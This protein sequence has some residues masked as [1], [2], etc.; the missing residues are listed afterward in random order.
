MSDTPRHDGSWLD[1]WG[2]CKACGG[3]IPH[4]HSKNCDIYKLQMAEQERDQ[5][6]QQLL[7]S[8]L[9]EQRMR[10]VLELVRAEH[11]RCMREVSEIGYSEYNYSSSL[12]CAVNAALSIPSD[13]SL[14]KEIREALLKIVKDRVP[15]HAQSENLIEEVKLA[16]QLLGGGKL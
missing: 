14:L 6:K 16:L 4:G 8:Q 1:E 3:E 12:A 9:R 5:L 2:S 7:A 11:L 13:D 15:L 10:E